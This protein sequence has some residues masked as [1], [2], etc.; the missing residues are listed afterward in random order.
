MNLSMNITIKYL[1]PMTSSSDHNR[2][3]PSVV[4]SSFGACPDFRRMLPAGLLVVGRDSLSPV[5]HLT[6]DADV[7]APALA[8]SSP[9]QLL[10]AIADEALNREGVL[11]T[12]APHSPLDLVEAEP[13]LR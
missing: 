7:A 6:L 1:K 8:G 12:L 11:V 5:V 10:Q 13:S 4:L 9:A 2:L 3:A